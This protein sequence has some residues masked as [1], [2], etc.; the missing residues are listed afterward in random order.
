MIDTPVAFEW[1]VGEKRRNKRIYGC[2]QH[3]TREGFVQR[4]K[5][6]ISHD[7]FVTHSDIATTLGKGR[8]SDI[9]GSWS[10]AVSAPGKLMDIA[11][12]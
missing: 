9:N 11:F 1:N 5:K 4:N 8:A 3:P 10:A 6:K 12:G 7:D 2:F